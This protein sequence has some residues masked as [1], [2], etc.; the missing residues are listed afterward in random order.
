MTDHGFVAACEDTGQTSDLGIYTVSGAVRILSENAYTQYVKN[1][2][3]S[4][5]LY[6]QSSENYILG[7]VGAFLG[8]LIGVALIVI[9]GQLG[10]VA[11]FSGIVMGIATVKGYEL[12]AKKF[13]K[14]AAV[15]CLVI[16][17]AMTYFANELDWALLVARV[18][19]IDIITAFQ[20]LSE[21]KT[22]EYIDMTDYTTN[23]LMLFAFTLITAGLTIFGALKDNANKFVTHPL[24][25]D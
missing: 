20:G 6:G 15:I 2:D 4:E 23:L 16:V 18:A 13:S 19:E 1:L 14:V 10:F 22:L 9:L 24:T 7:T 5:Q 12:L 8:S 17:V 11:A 21:L 25:E 3:T